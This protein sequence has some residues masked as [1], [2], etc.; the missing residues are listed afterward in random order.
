M[1]TKFK[2]FENNQ[3][4]GVGDYVVVNYNNDH[5]PR[6]VEFLK[7]NIGIIS[8][9]DPTCYHVRFE[10]NYAGRNE[11]HIDK[12]KISFYSKDKDKVEAYLASKK[13]N[14]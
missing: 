3:E 14:L 4:P 6:A 12:D 7:N 5:T 10:N 9:L 2:I 1:V 13:Y 11:F 8:K